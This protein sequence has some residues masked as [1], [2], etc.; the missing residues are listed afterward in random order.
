[1][2]SAPSVRFKCDSAYRGQTR[3]A[4]NVF[5]VINVIRAVL[6]HMRCFAVSANHAQPGDPMKLA[7]AM[8]ALVN[9]PNPPLRLALGS[10]TVAR[11]EAKNRFFGQELAAW[12]EVSVSTDFK[13]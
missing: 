9:A 8:L 7:E 6:P 2:G 5:G 13:V 10:D 12:R 4:T 11:I 3:F 1:M